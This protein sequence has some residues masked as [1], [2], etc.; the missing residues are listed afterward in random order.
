MI[1]NVTHGFEGDIDEVHHR[2][3]VNDGRFDGLLWEQC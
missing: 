1:Y 2:G 3:T